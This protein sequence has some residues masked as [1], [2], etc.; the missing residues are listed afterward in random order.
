MPHLICRKHDAGFETQVVYEKKLAAEGKSRFDFTR[1]ELYTQVYDFVQQ[2]KHNFENQ[3]RRL[4]AS[5]DWSRYVF[6][7]DEKIITRAYA[8]FKQLWD[9]G[10]VYRGERLV[11]FCTHHGT[12][13]ADIEVE[14]KGVLRA[15]SG[16]SGYPL[17][18][19]SGEVVV[20]TTRPETM[21]GDTGVAVHLMMETL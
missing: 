10:L 12:A 20:A 17:V 8:T 18:D 13:F 11:N 6:T 21:L 15:N 9:D 2:N 4:G 19:G 16:T 1:E 14:H 5:C 7:L 3:F